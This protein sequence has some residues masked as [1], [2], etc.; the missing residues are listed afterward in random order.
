M[1]LAEAYGWR[2]IRVSRP[3]EFERVLPDFLYSAQPAL[4]D[5]RIATNENVFPMVAP[6][7]GLDDVI[8]AVSV[9][10]ITDMI[11]DGKEGQR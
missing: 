5:L 6:G 11:V 10:D 2:A 8:G 7:A 4:M 1:K 9:G 3:E